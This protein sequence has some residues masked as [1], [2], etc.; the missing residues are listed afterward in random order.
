V[1]IARG[2]TYQDWLLAISSESSPVTLEGVE[3]REPAFGVP[4]RWIPAKLRDVA[5]GAGYAVVE[6]TSVIATHLA[7]VIRRH[8]HEV[9]TRQETKRLLDSLSDTQPKLVD[10][11]VPRVLSLGEIEKIL[12]Q[13]LREQVSIRNLPVILETL[14]DAAAINRSLISLVEAVRQAL[15]RALIQPLLQEDGK[16]KVLAVDPALEDEISRAFDPQSA[17][18]K[19]P[20]LQTTFLRRVLDGLRRVAGDQIAV[21]SPILLCGSP[22]RFHLRRLLEPFVPRIVVISPAEIPPIVPVQS[23]GVVQ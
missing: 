2:E 20:A 4:A 10:E 22:A 17:N 3:T 1:E 5:L 19:S 23:L 13:L 6:Q 8:A 9:L 12:Q 21:A 15:G 14:I 7:E 16:L 11:L 18:A